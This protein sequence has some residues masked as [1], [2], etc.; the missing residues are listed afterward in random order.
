MSNT[1]N[2]ASTHVEEGLVVLRARV[3]GIGVEV[4]FSPEDA[5]RMA[6]N[7]AQA[8]GEAEEGD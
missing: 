6:E 4:W 1:E 5:R 8:A 3:D 7:L 2:A